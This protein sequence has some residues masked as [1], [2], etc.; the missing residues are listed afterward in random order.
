MPV[1]S[2]DIR[3][4]AD[5]SNWCFRSG[6][7]AS[8]MPSR[9]NGRSR[10]GAAAKSRRLFEL[11]LLPFSDCQSADHQTSFEMPRKGAAPQ[12]EVGNT[13]ATSWLWIWSVRNNFRPHPEEH[14]E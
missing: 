14:R 13:V 8:P 9:A 7:A 1:R 11:I 4:P 5:P 10:D 3:P 6:S 2:P 12:D